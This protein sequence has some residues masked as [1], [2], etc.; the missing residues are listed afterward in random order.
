MRKLLITILMLIIT[1]T[2]NDTFAFTV[3][4]PFGWRI[5]PISRHWEFHPGI[6]IPLN[7]GT[8]ILALIDGKVAWAGPRGGYG[9]TVILQH[10]DNTF[11]LYGHCARVTV[12]SGQMVRAGEQIGIVGSTGESTGPHVHIEYWV[13]NQYVDPMVIWNQAQNHKEKCS[14]I[15]MQ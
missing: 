3:S 5:N 2:T 15:G 7:Y 10:R 1:Y 9:N 12:Q 6:D 4:S 11:T 13:D 14:T 8:P